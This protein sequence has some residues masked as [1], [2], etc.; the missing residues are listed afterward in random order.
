TQSPI[1]NGYA[2][3][4][5]LREKTHT[6]GKR[7]SGSK[8]GIHSASGIDNP[9]TVGAKQIDTMLFSQL[10]KLNFKKPAFMIHFLESCGDNHN[11]TDSEF[12]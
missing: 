4:T 1:K 8:R 6:S 5:G 10:R 3:R 11:R 7:I 12:K 9:K 2:K